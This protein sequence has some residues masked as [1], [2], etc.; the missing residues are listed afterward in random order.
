V[1]AEGGE[2]NALS[3]RAAADRASPAM[4]PPPQEKLD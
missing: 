4:V 1:R 3:T 2:C